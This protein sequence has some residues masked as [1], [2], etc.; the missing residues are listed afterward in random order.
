MS[1]GIKIALKF[2]HVLIIIKI[3]CSL[4]TSV[5]ELSGSKP[6]F[7][8]KLE[9]LENEDFSTISTMFYCIAKLY[10]VLHPGCKY[11]INF[12]EVEP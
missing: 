11:G 9:Q 2:V 8:F 7:L 4:H 3:A 6:T 12:Q 5:S 10:S 1:L